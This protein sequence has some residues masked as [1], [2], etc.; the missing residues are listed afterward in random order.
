MSNNKAFL[1]RD[2]RRNDL[3]A[4]LELFPRLASFELPPGRH[5]E[6]LW[7]HDA[8]LLKSW[9]LGK[10]PD[11]LV[12]LAE[13]PEGKLLGLVVTTLRPEHLSLEPS[14]HLEA[15]TVDKAA[16]GLGI[17]AALVAT[18][19]TEAR[20]RGAL[21]ITLHVFS[22]NSRARRLYSRAG[23]DEELIRCTKSLT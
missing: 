1:I 22:S 23:Y 15:I 18:T 16:E 8:K 20:A 9:A 6:H 4:M 3:D 14:A 13:G 21:S 12:H 7:M 10:E 2:A 19:E 5:P 11:C 17:G